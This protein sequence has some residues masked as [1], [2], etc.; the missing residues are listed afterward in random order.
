MARIKNSLKH[1]TS[2]CISEKEVAAVKGNRGFTVIELVVV[3]GLIG[4]VLSLIFSPIIFS[5][6]SFHKQS[7]SISNVANVR[8]AINYLTREI[9]KADEIVAGE[10]SIT[11]DSTVYE[12]YEGILYKEGQEFI[13]G[14]GKLEVSEI[15]DNENRRIG[16]KIKIAANGGQKKEYE[17]SSTLV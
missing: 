17:L 1:N 3:L 12:V 11:L 2:H 8:R 4:L 14:I 6:K 9:R 16:I 13:E 5:Y 10:N 15:M 7:Q